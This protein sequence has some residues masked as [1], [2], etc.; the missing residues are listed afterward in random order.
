MKSFDVHNVLKPYLWKCD[1]LT[2]LFFHEIMKRIIGW[3]KYRMYIKNKYILLVAFKWSNDI[4]MNSENYKNSIEISLSVS[5]EYLTMHQNTSR[6]AK[7]FEIENF[8]FKFCFKHSL[9]LLKLNKY[10]EYIFIH[11]FTAWFKV[12]DEVHIKTNIF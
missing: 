5:K 1:S 4:S 7:R 6:R 12:S 2:T 9:S 8:S 3:L 10:R 11:C